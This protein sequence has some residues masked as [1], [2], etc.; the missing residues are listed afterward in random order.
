MVV[1]IKEKI[2]IDFNAPHP[3]YFNKSNELIAGTTTALKEL[4]NPALIGW[5]YKEGKAGRPLNA[6]RDKAANIGTIA[7]EILK[8]K[9]LGYGIDNSNIQPDNWKL[10]KE[11][12]KSH[13]AWFKGL[14]SVKTIF[15][16]K[17]LVSELYQYGGTIDKYC[18]ISKQ[19]T[20]I[21]YKSG[22]DIYEEY[23][24]QAAAYTNLLIENGY[25][26]DRALI[27]NMPKESGDNFKVLSVSTKSLLNNGYFDVFLKSVEIY[28]AR[29]KIKNLK[30]VI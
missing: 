1:E 15:V 30:E 17:P 8:G 2:K 3:D 28:Y 19:H 10:A 5:A 25:K 18:T 4:A 9:D 21:D 11:C 6:K 20:L 26:V 22:K 13:N 12:I 27:V 24:Y 7:H 23:L 16:E 14:K 29:K